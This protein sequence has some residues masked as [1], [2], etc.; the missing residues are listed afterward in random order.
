MTSGNQDKGGP[1]GDGG[2]SAC[3]NI[4]FSAVKRLGSCDRSGHA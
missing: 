3:G 2:E 4:G 1:N